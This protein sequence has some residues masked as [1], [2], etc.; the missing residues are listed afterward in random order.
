MLTLPVEFTNLM[1]VFAP[2]FSWRVWQHVQ[3]LVAGAIPSASSATV[4][5]VKV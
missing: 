5:I 1:T 3:V 2:L 4:L